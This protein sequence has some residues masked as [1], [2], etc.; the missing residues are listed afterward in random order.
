MTPLVHQLR[1][2]QFHQPEKVD[3]S[4]RDIINC[5]NECD[6]LSILFTYALTYLFNYS[7]GCLLICLFTCLLIHL[8]TD[9]PT[10]RPT[11]RLTNL[12]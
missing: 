7:F 5:I 12:P 9:R 6:F 8:L 10:D 1:H 11:D 2:G 3:F 4:S